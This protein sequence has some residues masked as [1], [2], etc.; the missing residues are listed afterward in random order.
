MPLPN[1]WWTFDNGLTDASGN[2]NTLTNHSA[3]FDA[4][5]K[6]AGTHALVTDGITQYVERAQASMSTG[7]PHKAG[8]TTLDFTVGGWVQFTSTPTDF[9]RYYAMAD[10]GNAALNFRTDAGVHEAE[11]YDGSTTHGCSADAAY[12]VGIWYHVVARWKGSTDDEFAMFI[13]GVKQA[14]TTTST[15]SV[16]AGATCPLTFGCLAD[17]TPRAFTPVKLDDWFAYNIALSDQQIAA[18]AAVGVLSALMGSPAGVTAARIRRRRAGHAVS[19]PGG[20]F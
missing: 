15:A 2:G 4:S 6:R 19:S 1:G 16:S 20:F 3:T 14:F 8:E 7:Y 9:T 5:D 12:T 17:A 11:I 18:V 13:N 10:T